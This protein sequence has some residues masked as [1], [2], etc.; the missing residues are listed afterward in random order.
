MPACW[1]GSSGLFVSISTPLLLHVS[2]LDFYQQIFTLI[3]LLKTIIRKF[4]IQKSHKSFYELKNMKDI[5]NV[6]GLMTW[7]VTFC[8]S[9]AHFHPWLY[10]NILCVCEWVYTPLSILSYVHTRIH[11]LGLIAWQ[12]FCMLHCLFFFLLVNLNTQRQRFE[13]QENT[14]VP[15]IQLL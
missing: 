13:G 14:L 9:H 10:H 5:G 8:L 12:L 2:I 3:Q 15:G 1:F 11:H 4:D 6:C 7:M